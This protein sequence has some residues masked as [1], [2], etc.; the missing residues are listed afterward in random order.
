MLVLR[1]QRRT[2][3][4]A[5]EA[6]IANWRAIAPPPASTASITRTRRSPELPGDIACA[7]PSKEEATQILFTPSW[8][9]PVLF[10]IPVNGRL[11]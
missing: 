2:L 5:D 4:I 6:L 7:L 10:A 8:E 9:F 3:S 1:R 11:L